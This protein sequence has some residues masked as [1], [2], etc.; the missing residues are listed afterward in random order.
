MVTHNMDD[1]MNVRLLSPGGLQEMRLRAQSSR[2]R[3]VPAVSET[4]K[5]KGTE[6]SG[7]YKG[8]VYK[9][10]GVPPHSMGSRNYGVRQQSPASSSSK[11]SW[12]T[13]APS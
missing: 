3:N 7:V 9:R 13:T 12:T 5:V 10:N 1:C 11:M 6:G 2:L 8:R 4:Q